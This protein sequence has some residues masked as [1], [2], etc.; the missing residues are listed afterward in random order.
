MHTV[1]QVARDLKR[2][3]GHGV[4]VFLRSLAYGPDYLQLIAGIVESGY[5]PSLGVET[6]QG[7]VRSLG[8]WAKGISGV[9][10]HLANEHTYCTVYS[11]LS[12]HL[13]EWMRVIADLVDNGIH[14]AAR[15]ILTPATWQ[16]MEYVYHS[17]S[18]VGLH[19]F[20]VRP[21]FDFGGVTDSIPLHQCT[22][23]A[24]TLAMA[25]L[26]EK[27]A[28]ITID[29]SV[30]KT[31]VAQEHPCN[32]YACGLHACHAC[33]SFVPRQLFI[34]A[35]GDVYPETPDLG[36]MFCLGNVCREPLHE[37]LSRAADAGERSAFVVLC[38]DVFN[39]FL[40]DWHHPI[41]PWRDLLVYVAGDR[42]VKGVV[43]E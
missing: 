42:S 7:T 24:R 12:S 29:R 19:N 30:V 40:R 43:S 35:N 18:S 36:P 41:V 8:E 2:V 15:F 33:K 14:T 16:H 11:D 21:L 13:A 3:N 9:L 6:V 4:H 20:V 37:L 23:I 10:L 5:R 31:A 22:R 32:V 28:R 1:H 26:K 27:G 25:S 38:R 17:L 34:L 39:R